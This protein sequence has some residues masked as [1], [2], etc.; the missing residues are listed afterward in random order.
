MR[1]RRKG[2]SAVQI[3]KPVWDSAFHCLSSECPDTC[4][5][6]WEIPVDEESAARFAAMDGDWGE[7]LR[8]ALICADG[9]LQLERRNGRCVLLNDRNLCDLYAA[10]GEQ[11]LCRTCHLHPRFVA[12][13][14]G[15]RE[16]MPG[17]SC[18][19]WIETYLL[20]R[21]RVEFVTE[22]T[23]E[24]ILDYTD[25]DAALFFRLRK[26]REKAIAIA[27][28]RALPI[29]QRMEQLL[30]LGEELD[31][32]DGRCEQ[33]DMM[34]AYLAKLNTLEILTQQWK[35]EVKNAKQFIAVKTGVSLFLLEKVL[36]YDLF[37]F[38]LKGVYDGRVLPWIKLAVFHALVICV[39]G[40]GCKNET[41]QAEIIR[42]YSKEIEH[43][44]ENLE[45]LHRAFL[46]RSGRYSAAGLRK[47]ME[48]V[49]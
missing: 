2:G 44:A 33:E 1:E 46:R 40:N 14:G 6:G 9:E 8:A 31:G 30:A 25:I 23:D 22:E 21:E 49:L 45:S 17:L 19:A 7:R 12:Q 29:R 27:Q 10:C 34:A 36:V 39:V 35:C 37:R 28:D 11:A 26:A 16:I 32:A 4:C 47:A 18:P 42:I 43:N 24:P 41:E 38:F 15:R 13:Y 20:R 48:N 5:A 3:T